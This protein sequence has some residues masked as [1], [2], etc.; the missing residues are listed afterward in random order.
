MAPRGLR[1]C[2]WNSRSLINKKLKVETLIMDREIDIQTYNHVILCGDFNLHAPLWGNTTFN[3]NG[4]N[5]YP[6]LE[7]SPFIVLNDTQGTYYNSVNQT[8]SILDLVI[9]TPALANMAEVNVDNKRYG[10]DH[11]PVLL[12]LYLIPSSITIII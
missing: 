12:D 8:T 11:F 10:S 1:L 5:F 2:S 9:T 3:Q 4:R 6:T 7:A